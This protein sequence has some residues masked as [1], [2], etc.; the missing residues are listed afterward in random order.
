MK[1]AYTIGALARGGA[2]NLLLDVFRNIQESSIYAVLIKK[3]KKTKKDEIDKSGV[4]R[5]QLTHRKGHLLQ[6]LWAYR[7]IIRAEKVDI[8]HAQHLLD[9]IYGRLVVEKK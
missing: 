7:K 8:I 9:I 4:K 2:E 1:V 5:I 3:K 6:Y